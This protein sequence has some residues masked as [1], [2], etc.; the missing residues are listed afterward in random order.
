[1]DKYNG[2]SFGDAMP[3]FDYVYSGQ[4]ERDN[5]PIEEKWKRENCGH[6]VMK[7]LTEV[8]HLH[9]EI[10]ILADYLLKHHHKEICGSA[11]DTAINIISGIPNLLEQERKI[12]A[13]AIEM[14]KQ[15]WIDE[16]RIEE[17]KRVEE[18]ARKMRKDVDDGT[19]CKNQDG[20]WKNGYDCAMYDILSIINK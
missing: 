6:D 16:G 18:Y 1:M 12:M 9:K 2:K 17:K 14:S 3:S 20:E 7:C 13:G 10:D 11:V 15:G 5:Q 19:Y 8:E 4:K